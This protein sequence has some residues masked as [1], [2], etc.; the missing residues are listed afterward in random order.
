MQE[1]SVEIHLKHSQY[2]KADVYG[3][4]T[5]VYRC[6]VYGETSTKSPINII[7]PLSPDTVTNTQSE[8]HTDGNLALAVS[9]NCTDQ[10]RQVR[11]S[12]ITHMKPCSS[13]SKHNGLICRV[14][15]CT[16]ENTVVEMILV[17]I[18]F[19]SEFILNLRILG[20]IINL[21]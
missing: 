2:I 12:D 11:P 16:E 20:K 18:F 10:K 1:Y 3:V 8:H 4:Y 9:G 14:C 19:F 21:R 7:K 15:S 6:R 17:M 5:Y 13:C